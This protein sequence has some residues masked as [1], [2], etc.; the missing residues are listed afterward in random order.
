[1]NELKL[2]IGGIGISIE[3]EGSRIVDW[4]HPFYEKFLS[5]SKPQITLKVH[6]TGLPQH[7]SQLIFDGKKEG[8]WRLYRNNSKYI[9]ETF[10]TMT[11]KKNKVCFIAPDFHYGDVYIDPK[12]ERSRHPRIKKGPFFSLPWL[13]QPLAQLL[14]VNLLTEEEGIMVHGLGINDR[15]KGIAFVGESGAGKSTLAEFW[16]SEEEVNILSDEHIIIRKEKD[17]FWLYGTPWPGMAMAVSSQGVR[18][19]KIFFIGHSLENKIL[20]QATASALFPL[21]FL[22]FWDRERMEIIL[23]FCEELLGKIKCNKLG[24]IKDRSVIESVREVKKYE[25]GIHKT[26]HR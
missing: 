7:S 24:F 19:K 23:K 8:Y 5:N 21:L 4:P 3:W 1:M 9:I 13:M 17:Q 25:E 20:G 12:S 11:H 14:L 6:C 10:D 15:G 22:P 18:L 2:K 26:S 16:K